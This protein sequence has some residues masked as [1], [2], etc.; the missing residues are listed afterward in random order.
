MLSTSIRHVGAALLAGATLLTV[1][2]QTS[3]AVDQSSSAVDQR[4]QRIQDGLLPAVIVKGERVTT[5]KLADRMTTLHVPGVSVALIHDGNIE[6][7]R[8]FG[9]TRIGGPPVTP[10]TLFQAASISKPV[11]AMAVLNLV[12]GGRIDLDTDVNRYLNSWKVPDSPF[13]THAKVTVRELLT[14][15]AGLTVHGFAGYAAGVRL[16][17]LIEILNG[18][19]AANS[20][21]IR[22]DT[23]PNTIWRYSGGGYVV[24]QQLVEDVTG[25]PF[26][27]FAHDTVLA[28]IGMTKSTY[29][30]PLPNSR[31]D[32]IALPY[33]SNGQPVTGGPHVYPEM[34]PAGLWTTPSDL[35]RYAIEVQ[36]SLV[37]RANHALS[38]AMVRRMLKPV[39]DHQG[40]GP[41]IGGSAEHPYFEHGGANE[42]YRCY[43]VAYDEGDGVVVMTNGDNGGQLAS[44]IVRTVAHEYGWPDFVPAERTITKVEP[45]TLDAYVGVYRGS[46]LVFTI[47]RE[48]DQLVVQLTGQP[49]F[50]MFPES[51]RKFFLKAVDAQITFDVSSEGR[52]RQLTLDQN[53]SELVATRLGDAAAK[54]IMDEA[55]A[56][57][58][59][60]A[61][62]YQEQKPAEGSDT[63]LRS[64]I[65]GLRSGEPDYS[66]MRPEFAN[67]T[68]QQLPNW[69]ATFVQL[70]P[71]QSMIFKSVGQ[72]GA[73]IYD[74]KF[75]N[76]SAEF[77][78]ALT[79]DGK[80]AGIRFEPQ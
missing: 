22:V 30:Q 46:G 60:A 53:R 11:A 37:G 44:E 39:K 7:A 2:A 32:E 35:A 9:V 79:T 19:G 24:A 56:R 69:K 16:P 68:R 70:G 59:V 29:E 71:V 21:P 45:K 1:A 27:K 31:T 51:E 64:V 78:I 65:E 34:A 58:A 26:P 23:E 41:E 17:T 72:G 74:V 57:V 50:P 77:R 36:Q 38:V 3:Y 63:M 8:G 20:A 76:G 13:T 52:A 4:I 28:P 54:R 80:V 49:R 10:D 61:K 40:L 55:A 14:H 5:T 62:R 18:E 15:T 66:Q 12:E 73:D 25:Q 47:T 6:W 67:V 43:L 48:G 42:G 75:K 33:R